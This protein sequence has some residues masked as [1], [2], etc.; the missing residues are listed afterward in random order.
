MAAIADRALRQ[1]RAAR[2]DRAADEL[3]ENR[4]DTPEPRPHTRQN[5]RPDRSR[6]APRAGPDHA[7]GMGGGRVTEARSRACELRDRRGEANTRSRT[8]WR[9]GFRGGPLLQCRDAD[10]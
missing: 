10:R 7:A 6:R 4:V 1:R 5:E 3:A 8:T 9:R 2:R